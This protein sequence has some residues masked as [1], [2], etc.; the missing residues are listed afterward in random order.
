MSTDNPTQLVLQFSAGG[1]ADTEYLDHLTRQLRCELSEVDG[2]EAVNFVAG[3]AAPAGAKSVDPVTLGVLAI[4][5]LPSLLPKLVDFVQAWVL[6]GQNRVVK[7]KGKLAGQ[8]IEFE[9]SAEE[10]KN[11]LAALTPAKDNKRSE[12]PQ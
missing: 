11:L 10:L 3:G 8:E 7:F 12:L 4:A 1:E 2:V 9:G 6:R 5:V